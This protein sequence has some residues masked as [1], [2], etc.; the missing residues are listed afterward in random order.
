MSKAMYR[1]VTCKQLRQYGHASP[2]DKVELVK[3]NCTCC[4]KVT[5]HDFDHLEAMSFQ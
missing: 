3:I 5:E 4:K 2:P 1:C